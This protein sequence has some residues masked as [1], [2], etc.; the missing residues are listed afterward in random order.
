[1]VKEESTG[2]IISTLSN[3]RNLPRARTAK[4]N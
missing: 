1:V 2:A 4:L 3:A